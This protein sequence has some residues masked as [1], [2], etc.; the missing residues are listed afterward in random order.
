V[1]GKLR[2]Y[3]AICRLRFDVV[4]LSDSFLH[5]VF[6]KWRRK[7]GRSLCTAKRVDFLTSAMQPL[8]SVYP[9]PQLI[10]LLINSERMRLQSFS[11]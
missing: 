8:K 4:S 6:D 2:L 3:L 1:F 10:V 9:S 11:V 7:T 5:C